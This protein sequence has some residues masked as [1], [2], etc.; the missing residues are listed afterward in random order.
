ME[1][2]LIDSGL[3]NKAGHSYKLA[4]TVSQALTRRKLR[5]A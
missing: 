3:V 5:R 2:I 1:L 4:K